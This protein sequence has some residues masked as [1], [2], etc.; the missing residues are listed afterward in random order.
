MG[1]IFKAMYLLAFFGFL[2]LSN[3][4]PVNVKDFSPFKHLAKG[5]IFFSDAYVTILI[6]WSKT[7][8]FSNQAR[9]LKIPFLHNDICPANALKECVNVVPGNNNAPL[10]QFN[11]FGKWVPITH[12]RVR[13]HLKNVLELLGKNPSF[14]T[15]HSFRC[16]GATFAFNHDV[17]LQDIQRHGTW[18]SDCV[19]NY[20]TDS[21]DAGTQVAAT[22]ASLL[23]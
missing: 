17:P 3:L 18:T 11:L 4:A 14:I 12:S 13:N 20:V 10:F 16:S 15:F 22:F 23:S 1:A 8:Q 21:V 2:R 6:K 7:L 5:D 19:W 9:L